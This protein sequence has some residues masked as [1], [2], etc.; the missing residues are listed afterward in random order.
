MKYS[1]YLVRIKWETDN[2]GGGEPIICVYLVAA[3]TATKNK[4][5]YS[6]TIMHTRWKRITQ[7]RKTKKKFIQIYSLLYG[8]ATLYTQSVCINKC[9]K[10]WTNNMSNKIVN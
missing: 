10:L 1:A 7:Q 4:N 2:G 8:L 5:L 9:T 6:I 3:A